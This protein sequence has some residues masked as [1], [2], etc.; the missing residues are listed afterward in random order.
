MNMST[1]TPPRQTQTLAVPES[2][3]ITHKTSGNHPNSSK[4]DTRRAMNL[5]LAREMSGNFVGPMPPDEFL[6][7][8]LPVKHP[9]VQD[10]CWGKVKGAQSENDMYNE[11]VSSVSHSQ[12]LAQTEA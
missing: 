10:V 9:V 11:I 4:V 5:S 8:F 6:E 7:K 1:K 12:Q 2:T 3:P